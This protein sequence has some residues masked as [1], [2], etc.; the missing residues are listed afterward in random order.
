MGAVI[1]LIVCSIALPVKILRGI[2]TIL[3]F[4]WLILLIAAVVLAILY[5]DEIK[6]AYERFESKIEDIKSI[7][8]TSQTQINEISNTVNEIKTKVDQI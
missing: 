3:S 5:W 2:M 6:N 4:L 8:D 1:S 7:I